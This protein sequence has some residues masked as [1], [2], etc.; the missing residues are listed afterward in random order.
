MQLIKERSVA[1]DSTE[2]TKTGEYDI[3]GAGGGECGGGSC[4]LRYISL[5]GNTDNDN[6]NSIY[7]TL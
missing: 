4:Q 6:N 3:T 2:S 5:H 7:L 1:A